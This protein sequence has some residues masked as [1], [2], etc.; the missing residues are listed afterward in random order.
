MKLA[1][2]SED[3]KVLAF[4]DAVINA[5][6]IPSDAVEITDAQWQDLLD[7]QANKRLINGD[8]VDVTPPENIQAALIAYAAD[9]RWQKETGGFDFNG[10]H[11]ATDDRSKLLITGAREAAKANASFTTPWVTSTGVIAELD[12]A[13]II[14]LSDAIGAH[15]NSAFGIYS[16]V[17]PQILDGTITDQSQIDAAFA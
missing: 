14:A 16:E 11:I 6:N 13:A 3:G 4:Y 17:V 9:K 5:D 8:V 10:L 2:L 7:D 15:V 1:T 12:A